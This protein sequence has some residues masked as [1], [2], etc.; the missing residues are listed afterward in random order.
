[1]VSKKDLV[2]FGSL[3]SSAKSLIRLKILLYLYQH[4]TFKRIE[5]V[6]RDLKYGSD[7]IA[8]AIRGLERWGLVRRR[9]MFVEL[10]SLGEVIAE[11]ILNIISEMK[12]E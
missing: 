7:R 1:V 11:S 9:E 12:R 2:R 4:E 5:T 6:E 10:T 3:L 8:E